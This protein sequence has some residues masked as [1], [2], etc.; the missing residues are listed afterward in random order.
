LE[1]NFNLLYCLYRDIGA[2]NQN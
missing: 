1:T 2:L